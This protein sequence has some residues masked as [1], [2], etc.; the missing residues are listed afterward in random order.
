RMLDDGIGAGDRPTPRAHTAQPLL[1]DEAVVARVLAGD[2]AS[3]ELIMRRYNQRIF[4]IVRAITADDDEAGDVVQETYVRAYE[5]L[6]QFEGRA[7]F[8][9]WLTR[10]AI[11]EATARS[12]RLKR[13]RLSGG[14]HP[15]AGS[16]GGGARTGEDEASM[17]ELSGLLASAIDAL[18]DEL[19]AVF[20]LRA[21]EEL[22]T[23]E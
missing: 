19:R 22:D 23:R 8:S 11:H 2:L 16:A 21:V 6:A 5:H 17:K 9:T 13:M 15:D 14:E 3:F 7:K 4:R 18:P 1:T 20:V 10:I 12:R